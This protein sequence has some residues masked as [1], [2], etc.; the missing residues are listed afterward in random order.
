MLTE[1]LSRVMLRM[2]L[3]FMRKMFITVRE[4]SKD[5]TPM[6]RPTISQF[7]RF[8][9][10]SQSNATYRVNCLIRKGYVNRVPSD[11]DRREFHLELTDKFRGCGPAFEQSC[12]VLAKRI[13]LHMTREE[14]EK[15]T[16]VLDDSLDKWNALMEK[17][18]LLKG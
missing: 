7:A 5:L 16:A 12:R 9:G 11:K 3:G 13:A 18:D 14:T 8:A 2:R 10:I 17:D 1:S 15:L 6:E 4:E